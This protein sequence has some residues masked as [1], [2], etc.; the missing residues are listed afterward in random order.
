MTGLARLDGPAAGVAS[1]W[2]RLPG[3]MGARC[4]TR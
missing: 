1:S 3:G 4:E 2:W